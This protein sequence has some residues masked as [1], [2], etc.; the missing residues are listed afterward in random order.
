[1]WYVADLLFAQPKQEGKAAVTCEASQVLLEAPTAREAYA[2]AIRW[3]EQHENGEGGLF[4]FRFVGVE[5]LHSLEEERPGDGSEIGGG[6]YES[7]D[8]W[9][10]RDE[11]IPQQSDIPVIRYE[12]NPDSPIGEL[13]TEEQQ[14]RI[15]KVMGK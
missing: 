15:R 2:K 5:H 14:E 10:R 11:L 8:V 6:F 12:A 7:P 9:E 1:M 3:A 4:N 13:L